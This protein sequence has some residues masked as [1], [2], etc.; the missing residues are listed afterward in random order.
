MNNKNV[1]GNGES[2]NMNQSGV[3]SLPIT[4]RDQYKR[5]IDL[6][7]MDPNRYKLFG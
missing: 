5:A 7:N 6:Y 4:P 1:G 3:A 2:I